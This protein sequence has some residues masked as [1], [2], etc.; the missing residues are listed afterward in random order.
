MPENHNEL[1]EKIL[2]LAKEAVEQDKTLRQEMQVGEKF[3]FIRD[4]L[5]ALFSHIDL[6]LKEMQKKSEIKP[7]QLAEDEV[8][9][10]VYLFNAHGLTFQ[11]WYKMLNP[12]VFYEYSV[13]RPIYADKANI[14]AFIRSR[15]NKVQHGYLAV[16]IKKEHIL[17]TI[18]PL[19]DV[20]GNP[21][22]KV[23]EGSLK[24]ERLINFT[25]NGKR[26]RLNDEGELIKIDKD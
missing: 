5:G 16:A 25:H 8:I 9:V 22:I 7:D 12:N 6:T 21:V 11:N 26:Y 10:Y 18:E 2:Y 19:K 15:S 1:K 24:I 4:R 23:K 3:R 14:E 13:N 20:I 17:K